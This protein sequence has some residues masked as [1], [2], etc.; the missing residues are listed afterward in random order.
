MEAKVVFLIAVSTVYQGKHAPKRGKK[1]WQFH[2]TKNFWPLRHPVK[3]QQMPT[4][5]SVILT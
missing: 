3:L 4:Y 2:C 5:I 1:R